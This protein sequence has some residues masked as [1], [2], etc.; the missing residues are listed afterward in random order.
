M[1][2]GVNIDHIATVRQARRGEAPDPVDAARVCER[3][4]ATSIVCHLREDRRHIQ[5]RDVARLRRAVGVPLNLEMSIAPEI[6]RIALAIKPA[7]VTLVPERRQE[8][9]TEGGLDVAR[10]GARL[11]RVISG[12]NQAGILVSLFV[13]PSRRQIEA[14][15][16]A[17]APIVELH[18]GRY[19]GANTA[20]A[21]RR[22]L[23]ALARAA[24]LGRSLG[25]AVAAGHGLD[26]VNVRP[27]CAIAG[28]EEL[29]IGFAIIAR[30]LSVGLEQ[31]VR[32][33][34]ALLQPAA[35]TRGTRQEA[36]HA[37][38]SV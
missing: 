9:T 21:R 28:I 10:H 36:R 32:E 15:R 31:A 35:R 8:L 19:A 24:G 18:T 6:V 2:L 30:A 22:E 33:M 4:G 34:A 5:E 14:A 11:R 12:F 37:I 29:N 16:S 25:L 13:D 23:Q 20:Q 7:Q 3:A 26:Y 27:V 17:G 38:R 1:R